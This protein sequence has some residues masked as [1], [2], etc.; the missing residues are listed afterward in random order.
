MT[1]ATIGIIISLKIVSE[2]TTKDPI[3]KESH[4][5]PKCVISY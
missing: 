4:V 5:S 1:T 2:F 3:Y